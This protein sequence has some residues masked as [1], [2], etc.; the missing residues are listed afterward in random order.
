MAQVRKP[1]AEVVNACRERLGDMGFKKRSGEI[2]TMDVADDALGWLGL[3]RAVGRRDGLL[4][5]NPVVGVRHQAIERLLAELKDQKFHSYIP[6]TISVHVGYLMPENRYQP[7]LFG[8]DNVAA[9]ADAMAEAIETFGVPFMRQHAALGALTSLMAG[10]DLGMLEQLLYRLPIAYHLL[11]EDERAIVELSAALDDL[12]ERRDAAAERF[13][14]F[15]A[16]FQ[17]RVAAGATPRR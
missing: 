13:R 1:I 15:A 2:F 11:G 16:A 9:Q 5:M 17:D 6:P 10:R 12:A 4:E 3:N 7:W 14:G 8:E